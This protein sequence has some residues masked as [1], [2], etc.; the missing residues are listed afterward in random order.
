MLDDAQL[1]VKSEA[2]K[3]EPI[4]WEFYPDFSEVRLSRTNDISSTGMQ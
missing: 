4:T 3:G 2:S 1:R